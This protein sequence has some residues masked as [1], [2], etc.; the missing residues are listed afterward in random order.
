MRARVALLVVG[1]ICLTLGSMAAS[2]ADPASGGVQDVASPFMR[3]YGITPPPYGN[4]DFCRRA[5][6]EC[7]ADI[8]WK[9]IEASKE[10]L[11]ALD[12]VN[13]TVNKDVKP[14]TDMEQ[15]GVEDY[16]TIPTSGRG[17]C[18]DYALLKRQTLMRMG[19]PASALLMT[20]VRDENYQGHAVLTVRIG[21]GD[22]ILDNKTNEVKLWSQA[23]YHYV[24]RQSYLNPQLWMSLDSTLARPSIPVAVSQNQR[25]WSTV[26]TRK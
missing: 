2:A 24:M 7:V 21:K 22:L 16:W 20:V 15:Y 11:A 23:P 12:R 10:A 13:R 6:E 4:V 17:D 3:V 9:R 8:R 14:M 26:V 18:E 25:Q 5:P 19:W 1:L